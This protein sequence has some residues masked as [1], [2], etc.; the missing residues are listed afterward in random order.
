MK[1]EVIKKN[2]LIIK[3][4]AIGDLLQLTPAIRALASAYPGARI[5][6]LVGTQATATLFLHHPLVS[7]T[8]IFDRRGEHRTILSLLRL[9]QQIRQG[10]YSLVVHFQRSNLKTWLLASAALPC[11]VLVY[12]KTRGR[13]VHV[14]DDYLE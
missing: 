1:K 6:L 13:S 14:V 11:R 4:G 12:H 3:P 10:K 8:I 9:W 2:I 7:D 5:T